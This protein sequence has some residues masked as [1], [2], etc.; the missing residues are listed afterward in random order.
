MWWIIGGVTIFLLGLYFTW[1]LCWIGARSE[2]MMEDIM[3]ERNN[4]IHRD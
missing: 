4:D 1:A 2:E 3:E